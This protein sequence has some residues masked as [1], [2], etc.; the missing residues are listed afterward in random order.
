MSNLV[1]FLFIK[2]LFH[3]RYQG[4]KVER[5]MDVAF[6]TL[7]DL[8]KKKRSIN[9]ITAD[10]KC[11]LKCMYKI[12]FLNRERD[13]WLL[14]RSQSTPYLSE[15]AMLEVSIKIKIEFCQTNGGAGKDPTYMGRTKV[16]I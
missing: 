3:N 14:G 12:Q 11:Y 7:I 5:S 1:E 8:E 13:G 4:N 6:K 2:N 16:C 9:I 15:A 10:K